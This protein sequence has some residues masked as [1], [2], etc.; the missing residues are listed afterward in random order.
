MPDILYNMKQELYYGNISSNNIP[1]A[2]ASQKVDIS[3][4]Y[5][6]FTGFD[7]SSNEDLADKLDLLFYN[8]VNE[9]GEILSSLV[10]ISN[11][12]STF[13]TER[14]VYDVT[15]LYANTKAEMDLHVTS[16]TTDFTYLNTKWQ[17]GKYFVGS[18]SP[19]MD[20]QH[21][22]LSENGMP[23]VKIEQF[24]ISFDGWYTLVSV[25]IYNDSDLTTP[26]KNTIA[27]HTFSDLGQIPAILL[28]D[29]ENSEDLAIDSNWLPLYSSPIPTEVSMA[30][31]LVSGSVNMPY[32]KQDF[33]ILPNYIEL[34]NKATIQ[35]AEY[36]TFGNP[37]SML[38]NKHRMI[39]DYCVS[40]DF[41]E[42][43]YILQGTEYFRSTINN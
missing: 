27:Y 42:A 13:D 34:Y 5:I 31:V 24:G 26:M 8:R 43:Q 9:I 21:V 28:Y 7:L 39:H 22:V 4:Y 38:R 14:K 32:L 35:Y 18:I 25:G 40:K 3:S 30:S 1:L 29:I 19:I 20:T 36:P 41:I 23:S 2:N 16:S 17:S 33:F 37:F 11:P 12:L 15:K 10:Y 6:G